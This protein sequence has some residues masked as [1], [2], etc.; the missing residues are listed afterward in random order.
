MNII[1]QIE[2]EGMK[3]DLPAISPGWKSGTG[4]SIL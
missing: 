4:T 1:D 3:K 2:Q